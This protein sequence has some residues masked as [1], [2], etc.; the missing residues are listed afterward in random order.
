MTS[1]DWVPRFFHTLL[2]LLLVVVIARI[3]KTNLVELSLQAM[4]LPSQN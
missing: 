4:N 1:F 2:A 3:P